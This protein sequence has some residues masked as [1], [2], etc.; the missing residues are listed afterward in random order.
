MAARKLYRYE[1]CVICFTLVSG[2]LKS[3]DM[4]TIYAKALG[5]SR[6][7]YMARSLSF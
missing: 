1:T 2:D 5:I 4:Q 6:V 7:S 3:D